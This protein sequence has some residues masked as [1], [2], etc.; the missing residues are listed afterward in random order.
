MTNFKLLTIIFATLCLGGCASV[1]TGSYQEV[2]LKVTCR[3][4]DYPTYCV[5]SNGRGDWKFRT[6]ETNL[7][8]R[9]NSQLQ[10]RC[11]NQSLGNYGVV[12][13]P[14]IN[15]AGIGNVWVGGLMGV[16]IDVSSDAF[17]MYP[18]VISFESSFCGRLSK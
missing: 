1:L 8:A 13:Y 9:D 15:P 4:I 7:I 11:E 18:S 17:W 2:T 5:A 12:Q 10:I 14:M 6:P 16:A 3:G